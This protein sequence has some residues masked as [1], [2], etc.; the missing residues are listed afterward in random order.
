LPLAAVEHIESHVYTPQNGRYGEDKGN[1]VKFER[2]Q[3][4]E[5]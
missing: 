2:I 5:E 4:K 1:R 3:T